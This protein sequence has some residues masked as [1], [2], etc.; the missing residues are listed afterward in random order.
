MEEGGLGESTYSSRSFS[1]GL[2]FRIPVVR[3]PDSQSSSEFQLSL[4][5]E[6]RE[7]IL[8]LYSPAPR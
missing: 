8:I 3:I 5:P 2:L 6:G 7:D 1:K 4:G